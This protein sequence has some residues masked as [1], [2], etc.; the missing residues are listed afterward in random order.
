MKKKRRIKE[1]AVR[2]GEKEKSFQQTGTV[3]DYRVIVKRE[4][5]QKNTR[6]KCLA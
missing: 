1:V 5:W 3:T 2:K 6:T 4:T